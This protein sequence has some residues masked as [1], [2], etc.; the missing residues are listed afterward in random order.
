ME[1]S[2]L[3][4]GLD[5]ELVDERTARVVVGAQCVRLAAAAVEREHQLRARV[6]AQR[7]AGDHGLELRHQLATAAERKLGVEALL[8]RRQPQLLE[9]PGRLGRKALARKI[10]E[11]GPPP[12][13]ERSLQGVRRGTGVAAGHRP[14]RV[15]LQAL[16]A[17]EV[18]LLGRD[19]DQVAR[20]AGHDHGLPAAA[21]LWV[22]RLAKLGDVALKRRGGRGWRRFAPQLVDQ[23]VGGHHLAR[24]EQELGEHA[25][26]PATSQCDRTAP[27]AH[28][29]WPEHEEVESIRQGPNLTRAD[30]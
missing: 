27:V 28:L 14:A 24:L 7:L 1:H 4:T 15:R 25:A 8:D 23:P 19:R 11:S 22:E 26:L 5:S 21:S 17:R 20:L 18:E 16:E 6:L 29:E 12:E 10:L 30:G 2:Q 13:R 9:A 3:A